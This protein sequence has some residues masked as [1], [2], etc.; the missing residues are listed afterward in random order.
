VGL[1]RFGRLVCSILSGGF[2]AEQAEGPK[3]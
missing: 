2:R 1:G 3:G